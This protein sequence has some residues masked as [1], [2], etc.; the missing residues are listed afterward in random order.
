LRSAV[1]GE[2]ISKRRDCF[3]DSS[4]KASLLAMTRENTLAMTGWR[5]IGLDTPSDIS[6]SVGGLGTPSVASSTN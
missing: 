4:V 2:A 5:E 6:S 3:V 1:G